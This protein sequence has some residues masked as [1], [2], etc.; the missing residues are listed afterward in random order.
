M[1]VLLRR[2]KATLG[3]LQGLSDIECCLWVAYFLNI[4]RR[5]FL[6]KACSYNNITL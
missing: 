1:D 4:N 3:T 5:R 2:T 6:K